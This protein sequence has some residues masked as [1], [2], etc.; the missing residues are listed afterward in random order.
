[1]DPGTSTPVQSSTPPFRTRGGPFTPSSTAD[2]GPFSPAAQHGIPSGSG[3]TGLPTY[4]AEHE[5]P[6]GS[7]EEAAEIA[8]GPG[9]PRA[10]YQS[11]AS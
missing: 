6:A 1:M 8:A 4:D 10:A 9:A 7:P 3:Y 5:H 2:P 11:T